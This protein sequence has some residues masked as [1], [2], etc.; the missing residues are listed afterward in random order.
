VFAALARNDRGLRW[1]VVAIDNGDDAKNALDRI[2]IPQ[3]V[4]DRIAPTALPQSSMV[5]SDEPLSR[6]QAV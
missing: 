3:D 4:L 5:I 1:T 6:E 2:S